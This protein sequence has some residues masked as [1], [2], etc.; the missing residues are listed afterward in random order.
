[1][2]VKSLSDVHRIAHTCPVKSGTSGKPIR[3][4]IVV[5]FRSVFG[6]ERIVS[7]AIYD[8]HAGGSGRRVIGVHIG[9]RGVK[10]LAASRV[11]NIVIGIAWM[12]NVIDA[13]ASIGY[14]S[15]L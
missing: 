1:M 6:E 12:I 11:A 13:V 4:E 10:D 2:T 5:G 8:N 14:S 7:G 3:A 9:G 15:S